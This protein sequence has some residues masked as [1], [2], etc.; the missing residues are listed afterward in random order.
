MMIVT[1]M[2]TMTMTMKG[3]A[4]NLILII[5]IEMMMSSILDDHHH[6]VGLE[7]SLMNGDCH[8]FDHALADVHDSKGVKMLKGES[9]TKLA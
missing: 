3:T 9:L 2:M 5:R 7:V 4:E 6:N 1:M 8:H